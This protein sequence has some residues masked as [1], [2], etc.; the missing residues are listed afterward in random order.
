MTARRLP[1]ATAALAAATALAVTGCS[2]STSGQGS[3][4]P[5][6]SGPSS[7]AA[8]NPNGMPTDAVGL[9]RLMQS[10][11]SGVKSAHVELSVTAAGQAIT[12]GGDEQLSAGKLAALDI[13]VDLPGTGSI[14]VISAGGRTY[15]KLPPALNKTGKPYVLVT[16]TSSNP[17]IRGLA[18]SLQ[19]GLSSASV[20]DYHTFVQAAESVRLR[21]SEQVAGVDTTHYS[22]VVNVDKLP[23]TVQGKQTLVAAG[24]TTIPVELWVD[25]QGRPVQVS[26]NLSVG[27]QQITSKDVISKYNE[28]VSISAPPPG[29]VAS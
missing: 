28:P 10:G 7:S 13:T 6:R 18:S 22:V 20:G 29:Q 9:G 15:A 2:S 17:T 14:E 23:D 1:A 12:G 24:V 19:T 27:S 11:V 8:A 21:G 26:E 5:A 16:P 3:T 4:A 25:R